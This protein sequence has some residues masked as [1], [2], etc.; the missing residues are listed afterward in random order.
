V[1]PNSIFGNFK[2]ATYILT[3][4]PTTPIVQVWV[5]GHATPL[6]DVSPTPFVPAGIL[7]LGTPHEW[8]FT[9]K[10]NRDPIAFSE[11]QTTSSVPISVSFS[12]PSATNNPGRICI[13]IPAQGSASTLNIS[14][15]T[16]ATYGTNTAPL[17]LSITGLIGSHLV[18]VPARISIIPHATT[19][20]ARLRFRIVGPRQKR[21]QLTPDSLALPHIDG[22]FFS[23][24]T[25]DH[26][27]MGLLVDVT[28]DA[29]FI[30]RV[31]SEREVSLAVSIPGAAP[32]SIV[33]VPPDPK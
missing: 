23:P 32:A 13:G 33:C 25:R 10:P 22:V 21:L 11:L 28:F 9:L 5:E 16:L 15:A 18:A 2:K 17:K 4:D 31:Q 14:I 1:L 3:S 6:V 12:A 26:T 24:P 29:S 27:G 19:H 8:V 7:E 20:R 30:K